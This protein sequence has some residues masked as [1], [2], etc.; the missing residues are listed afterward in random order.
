MGDIAQVT[1][2]FDADGNDCPVA[3]DFT[4]D[5]LKNSY[6]PL[7][8]NLFENIA[9]NDDTI[10]WPTFTVLA[11]VEHESN[12]GFAH[13]EGVVSYM[14][15]ARYV[16]QDS[17][18]YA[19]QDT[20]G[21]WTSA[22]V[23]INIEDRN[24]PPLANND[25]DN[26]NPF[27][28]VDSTSPDTITLA[29]LDTDFDPDAPNAGGWGLDTGS[30]EILGVVGSAGTA[31]AT[32]GGSINFTPAIGESGIAVVEYR[33]SDHGF[34]PVQTYAD[35]SADPLLEPLYAVETSG[36]AFVYIEMTFVVALVAGGPASAD[37]E[38]GLSQSTA[39]AH[40]GNG[41]V[42]PNPGA[43]KKPEVR[44]NARGG[45][46]LPKGVTLQRLFPGW[47]L[48]GQTSVAPLASACLTVSANKSGQQNELDLI[49][50]D[51]VRTLIDPLR[52]AGDISGLWV[53]PTAGL[54]LLRG[55]INT[56]GKRELFGL[57]VRTGEVS[58]LH[59]ALHRGEQVVE[60]AVS[61]NGMWAA[62]VVKLKG[63]STL[64][65]ASF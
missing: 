51:G 41:G 62:Y 29:V 6:I 52:V 54:A 28:S 12:G 14:P 43:V 40:T 30:I 42:G 59:N 2:S 38:T 57:D 17:F 13:N 15:A 9:A 35:V 49:T 60:F 53:S 48:E 7:P 36:S 63:Q 8:I 37:N 3:S 56:H 61:P 47:Q 24:T 64:Y 32:A 44:K 16:G 55:D 20:Q 26:A 11:A 22:T 25:G 58:R 4:V 46:A 23:T 19:V 33:V 39:T 1:V 21:Q 50:R 5:T 34:D 10:D 31:E 27:A 45:V 18:T 65:A